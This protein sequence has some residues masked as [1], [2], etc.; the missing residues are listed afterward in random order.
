MVVG[1]GKKF[2]ALEV[3]TLSIIGNS[4]RKLHPC[5][6]SLSESATFIDMDN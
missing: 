4:N 2:I 5:I 1:W 3:S 6:T